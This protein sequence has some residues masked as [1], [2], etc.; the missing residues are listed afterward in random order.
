MSLI[1]RPSGG[2]APAVR[3]IMLL[4][5]PEVGKTSLANRLSFGTF[6]GDY[7]RT[8]GVE[9]YTADVDFDGTS[10][11]LVLWDTDGRIQDDLV[12]STYCKGANGACVVCDV[13][14]PE[15]VESAREI[16]EIFE[17]LYPGRPTRLLANKVDLRPD[18]IVDGA[19]M[20]SAQNG[21]GAI[22]ALRGIARD[23]W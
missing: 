18:A 19:L 1:Q 10:H 16:V 15:T 8:I 21:V 20:V 6:T 5:E 4:G 2:R 14:R 11:R 7:K 13:T 17:D 12:A 9:L 23:C 22:E 3:K